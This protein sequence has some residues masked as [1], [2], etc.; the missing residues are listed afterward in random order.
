LVA[1]EVRA[2]LGAWE[3]P[4]PSRPGTFGFTSVACERSTAS[5]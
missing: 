2:K 4:E 5:I 3:T 1:D